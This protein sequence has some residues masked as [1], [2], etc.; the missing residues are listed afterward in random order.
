MVVEYWLNGASW[1]REAEGRQSTP[2]ELRM[3]F[4]RAKARLRKQ[5]EQALATLPEDHSELF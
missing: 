1:S 5:L 3:R 2:D 4:Q